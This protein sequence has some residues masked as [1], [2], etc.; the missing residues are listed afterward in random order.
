M[1]HVVKS[2]VM[3]VAIALIGTLPFIIIRWLS[4][5]LAV[6]FMLLPTRW[7]QVL[8]QNWRVVFDRAP[9]IRDTFMVWWHFFH[10]TLS[11][12]KVAT[13]NAE[14]YARRVELHAC[15]EYRENLKTGRPFIVLTG[16]LGCWE[17][18]ARLPLIIGPGRYAALFQNLRDRYLNHRVRKLRERD[19]V[20]LIERR[21]AW[22]GS[23]SALRDGYSVAVLADQNSGR[24]GIWCEFFGQLSSTSGLPA[25]LSRRTGAPVIPLFVRTLPGS[26]WVVEA[27][28]PME[29]GTAGVEER[30]RFFNH[31]LES[32]IRAYPWDWLWFHER[33]KLPNPQW[34]L[35]RW[36]HRIYAPDPAR[37]RLLRV[38]VRSMNW[39]GDAVM[40]LRALRDIK[41]SRPDIHLTVACPTQL[42][43]L[44]KRCDFVDEVL[45]VAGN[46]SLLKTAAA[47]RAGN[48]DVIVLM[49][50][51]WRVVLEAL[52]AGIPHRAGFRVR[53]RTAREITI[54]VPLDKIASQGEHQ[55]LTW[56]R[57]V[58][59][60]GGVQ[61]TQ[62]ARLRVQATATREAPYGVI[63]PGAAYGPAKRWP[64][65]RFAEAARLL[66]KDIPRWVIVG[67]KSDAP[68]CAEVARAL[69]TAEDLAGKTTLGELIDLLGHAALVLSNDSGVMH[70]AAATGAPTV[71]IFGSTS[72]EATRPVDPAAIVYQKVECSPCFERTCRYGHYECLLRVTPQLVVDEA[73]HVMRTQDMGC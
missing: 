11:A 14:Q 72:P 12:L 15:F 28:H 47:L 43:D 8:R 21:N 24:H 58:Q 71:G 26:R 39:L 9:S 67:A 64:A 66:S 57:A 16:H 52:L 17:V 56:L 53:G 70:L 62:P 6:V 35:G 49:P 25:L 18:L 22:R 13:L 50:N 65:E 32:R 45:S 61:I 54:K 3:S 40:H 68:A 59:Y 38:V 69:N 4:G 33:W 19:G 27:S 23:A 42:A 2:G 46:K 41:H 5:V 55:S 30:T 51:S 31:L 1:L 48:F 63:A 20:K 73:R 60:W 37:L 36:A 29:P 10:N 34:L 44:Y 7:N